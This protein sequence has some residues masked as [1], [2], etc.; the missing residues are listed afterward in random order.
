MNQ[1][2][3]YISL[4][5]NGRGV[6]ILDTS[7]GCSSGMANTDGGC[8][9]DC[10]SARSAKRYGYDF[11]KTVFR[12][13]INNSHR[14]SVLNKI[15]NIN[16]DFV[17]IGGSGDPSEDWEHAIYILQRIANVNKQI[18][19]IT[20]HWNILTDS[21]LDKIKSFRI[22]INTSVSA[23][24][25]IQDRDHSIE[26]YLR[27]KP[28]CKSVLR[29]IS[30]NFNRENPIGKYLSLVQHELFKNEAT[31]DT[32]FRPTNKN[33]FVLSGIV[34]VKKEVFNGSSQLASKHNRKTYMGKCGNCIEMCG[35]N[36]D[37]T[38]VEKRNLVN[39][40]KVF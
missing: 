22:C 18:V 40:L 8:Y 26:Q 3:K 35:I 27:L 9:G 15:N 33:P 6:S 39:Q 13:F 5:N 38:Y 16:L 14:Q 25:T 23:L 36:V 30:C 29:I 24:D 32:V 4:S 1:Y 21:Q 31:I 10:Y 34:N 11:T 17:R 12:D 7:I 28:F 20:R 37:T 19:I 2:S